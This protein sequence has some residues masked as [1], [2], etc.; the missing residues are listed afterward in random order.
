MGTK[1]DVKKGRR[2]LHQA[3]GFPQSK[4]DKAKA[5]LPEPQCP[6]VETSYSSVTRLQPDANRSYGLS[7]R[8]QYTLTAGRCLMK[9]FKGVSGEPK[10]LWN[11]LR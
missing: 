11:V 6:V 5:E 1:R 4:L 10:L 8:L 7:F 2:Q 3:G 9:T